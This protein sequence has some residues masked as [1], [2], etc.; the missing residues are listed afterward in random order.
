MLI[1]SRYRTATLI[2]IL[3]ACFNQLAGVNAIN[4]YSKV[5]FADVFDSDNAVTI[6]TALTGVSQIIGVLIAPLLG[7]KLGL[8]TILVFGSGC[9]TVCMG[10]VA[11]FSTI[12]QS[13]LVLVFILLFLIAFQ[14]SQGSF[15]FTY[16]AE[17]AEDASVAWAN[18]VLFTLILIL[19]LVTQQ[20]F[21]ALGNDWAFGMF[22]FFNLFATI[23]MQLVLKDI[24]G[25]SK[26]ESKLVYAKQQRSQSAQAYTAVA[27]DRD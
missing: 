12:D 18:F 17:V 5:I 4:F 6:G 26:T 8:K 19:S 20:L 7:A 13:T 9:C 11:I 15:F 21:D 3:L 16:V 2:G 14:A 25:M 10:L 1:D 24:S 22:A 23:T 27:S